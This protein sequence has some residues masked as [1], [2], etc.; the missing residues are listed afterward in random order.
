MI[1]NINA[2]EPEAF[3]LLFLW[4]H[5]ANG[6]SS[7][8]AEL[9]SLAN[10][11]LHHVVKA[12]VDLKKHGLAEVYGHLK[13][14]PADL[15]THA[16]NLF[17]L[18]VYIEPVPLTETPTGIIPQE[19]EILQDS[20]QKKFFFEPAREE[21]GFLIK[22]IKDSSPS[23]DLPPSPKKIFTETVL[24]GDV[25]D[26]LERTAG[27]RDPGSR[28]RL[29]ALPHMSVEYVER[30][31]C[32]FYH[33][34]GN[35]EVNAGRLLRRLET[36]WTAPAWCR[37]CEAARV[38]FVETDE[39]SVVFDTGDGGGAA[40]SAVRNDVVVVGWNGVGIHPEQA[41]Q[42]TVG[43]LQMEMPKNTFETWV[44]DA[45]FA[46]YDHGKF[47]IRFFNSYAADWV[48]SRLS[49]TIARILTGIRNEEVALEF[50]HGT[51]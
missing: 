32:Q 19:A 5:Q 1:T 27:L 29:A 20:L 9:M 46:G 35:E 2:L 38:V 45:R 22:L 39:P 13:H 37:K 30:M 17:P 16:F 49:S 15:T 8:L 4:I 26:V 47:T 40:P 50:V 36:R 25:L 31:A 11:T 41:W 3:K 43:Q 23:S 6:Q 44:R 18:P 33:V 34:E 24:D 10:M 28:A 7:T 51:T 21:E 14:S 48:Q 42:A 12:T